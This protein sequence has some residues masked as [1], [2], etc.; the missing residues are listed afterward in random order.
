MDSEF[1]VVSLLQRKVSSKEWGTAFQVTVVH[2]GRTIVDEAGGVDGT[3]QPVDRDSLF[4]IY[5]A[6]KPILALLIGI[7][8]DQGELSLND[9]LEDLIEDVRLSSSLQGITVESVLSHRAGLGHV[10]PEHFATLKQEDRTPFALSQISTGSTEFSQ[11]SEIL[12][13]ELLRI[14]IERLTG[15]SYVS[16]VDELLLRP[17]RLSEEILQMVTLEGSLRQR[18]RSNVDL[19]RSAHPVPLLWELHPSRLS[20][21]CPATGALA[22]ARGLA[23]L[24]VELL[25]T[26]KGGSSWLSAPG[27]SDLLI[28]AAQKA[29]D[30]YLGRECRFGLGFMVELADHSF[31]DRMDTTSF[32]HTG[33]H[34]MTFW[35]VQ[36]SHDLSFAVHING[37]TDFTGTND[38]NHSPTERRRLIGDLITNEVT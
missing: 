26:L 11:Y 32:G 37:S 4:S 18:L 22:T 38:L 19:V 28:P 2:R 35:A 36:P 24:G 13:W 12:G 27:L 6:G 15:Q 33:L 8:I 29:A 23:N 16:V 34:G 14:A 21:A 10:R 30:P 5:C 3:G 1:Q 17:T 25:E 31:G 7:L 20:V 9:C